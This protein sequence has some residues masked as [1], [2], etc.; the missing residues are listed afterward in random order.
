MQHGFHLSFYLSSLETMCKLCVSIP[1]SCQKTKED[2]KTQQTNKKTNIFKSNSNG[3][4]L[5]RHLIRYS[6]I[7]I[8]NILFSMYEFR[9]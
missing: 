5:Q 3:K 7:Q 6:Q 2:N 1:L 8:Y 4:K 9:N